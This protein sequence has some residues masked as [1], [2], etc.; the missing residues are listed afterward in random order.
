[1]IFQAD[2]NMHAWNV[3]AMNSGSEPVS[4]MVVVTCTHDSGNKPTEPPIQHQSDLQRLQ[5]V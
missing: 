4:I 5:T 2:T 1:M 3:T